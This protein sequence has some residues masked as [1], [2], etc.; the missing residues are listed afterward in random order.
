MSL[1]ELR[2]LID[3]GEFH[4]ATYRDF[5]KCHEGLHIYRRDPNGYRGYAHAG[6]VFHDSPDL[7]AAESMVAGFGMS[8]G[9]YGNG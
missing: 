9:S 5:G 7:R 2:Q 6:A 3:S 4:H 1:S 8:V